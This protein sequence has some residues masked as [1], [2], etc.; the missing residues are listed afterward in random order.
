LFP[1][2]PLL[3]PLLLWAACSPY[4][5]QLK[6][7]THWAPPAAASA[8]AQTLTSVFCDGRPRRLRLSGVGKSFSLVSHVLQ[9][10]L[11]WV[12]GRYQR[13]PHPSQIFNC[14]RKSMTKSPCSRILPT[15][16][17]ESFVSAGQRE[18]GVAAQGSCALMGD[19]RRISLVFCHAHGAQILEF[20]SWLSP[21]LSRAF[22]GGEEKAGIDCISRQVLIGRWRKQI[23]SV[24]ASGN[25]ALLNKFPQV[26]TGLSKANLEK[27]PSCVNL[28]R[29]FSASPL[30]NP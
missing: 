28:A 18:P 9:Y 10:T 13:Q 22:G 30:S 11:P 27:W 14:T 4:H 1:L 25:E 5:R 21:R 19:S 8:T 23:P 15:A 3:R 24:S 20:R 17:P 26:S 2:S 16:F 6:G 7:C 29:H 12:W